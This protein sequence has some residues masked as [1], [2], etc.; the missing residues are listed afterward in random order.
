MPLVRSR[1]QAAAAHPPGLRAR[2]VP[3]CCQMRQ[4]AAGW[5][6]QAA[7][8]PR[9]AERILPL[10]LLGTRRARRRARPCRP[11]K[12]KRRRSSR[13]WRRTPSGKLL[14]QSWDMWAGGTSHTRMR[15]SPRCRPHPSSLVA[16]FALQPGADEHHPAHLAAPAQQR[17]LRAAQLEPQAAAGR[18][19]HLWLGRRGGRWGGG[20][21]RQAGA[22]PHQAAAPLFWGNGSG[23]QRQRGRRDAADRGRLLREVVTILA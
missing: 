8:G 3:L 19:L 22:R 11:H 13:C 4:G 23:G 18:P 2:R 1:R 9:P 20:W 12:Q 10:H 16:F 14:S 15:S 6:R 21:Q 7:A 5:H 17:Q